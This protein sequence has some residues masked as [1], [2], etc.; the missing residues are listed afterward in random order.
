MN[1]PSGRDDGNMNSN[2]Y[3]NRGGGYNNNGGYTSDVYSS[4]SG[5]FLSKTSKSFIQ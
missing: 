3:T 2:N 1:V 5:G 4:G